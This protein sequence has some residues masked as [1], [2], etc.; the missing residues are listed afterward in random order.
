MARQLTDPAFHNSVSN[1][2][3]V[4]Q[5]TVE[6]ASTPDSVR[7]HKEVKLAGVERYIDALTELGV[8]APDLLPTT[9]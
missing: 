3:D 7:G 8:P 1:R 6:A 2:V 4:Y 5:S 9:P